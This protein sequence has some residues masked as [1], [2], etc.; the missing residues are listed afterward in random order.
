MVLSLAQSLFH[1][2]R[3]LLQ[4]E[5]DLRNENQLRSTGEASHQGN[6]ARASSHYLDNERPVV[7]D[8]GIADTIETLHNRVQ[9]RIDADR[10]RC[11]VDVVIDRRRDPHHRHTLSLQPLRP[12]QRAVPPNDNKAIKRPL[13]DS[14][15]SLSLP[16]LC[17]EGSRTGAPEE[18]SPTLN[19]PTNGTV[20]EGEEVTFDQSGEPTPDPDHLQ[21][22]PCSTTNRRTNGSVHPG[23]VPPTRKNSYAHDPLAYSRGK[24][25]SKFAC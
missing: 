5:R 24:T 15:E 20:V 8:R 4:G 16:L 18:G 1:L 2:G 9:R 13:L 12:L 10:H 11:P 25:Q 19:D 7:R 14:R 6:V 3:H 23:G 17:E 22:A 21:A